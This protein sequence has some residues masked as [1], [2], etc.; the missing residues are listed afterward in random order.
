MLSSELVL[1]SHMRQLA[2]GA[3]IA[4]AAACGTT[5]PSPCHLPNIIFELACLP[6]D[7]DVQCSVARHEEGGLGCVSTDV[8]DV[9]AQGSWTSSDPGIAAVSGAGRFKTLS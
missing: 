8:R 7:S 5:S 3:T 2:V 9:T 6:V 1:M 4:A